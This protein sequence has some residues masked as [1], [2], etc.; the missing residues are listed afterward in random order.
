MGVGLT[1]TKEGC[2]SLRCPAGKTTVLFFRNYARAK[3]DQSSKVVRPAR[4]GLERF[5]KRKYGEFEFEVWRR[6]LGVSVRRIAYSVSI[7]GPTGENLAYLFYYATVEKAAEAACKWIDRAVCSRDPWEGW[8]G[9]E[10]PPEPS[11]RRRAKSLI[12]P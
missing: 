5:S 7:T 4:T 8:H 6:R 3:H 10:Q 11:R 12:A 9:H 1:K 2:L